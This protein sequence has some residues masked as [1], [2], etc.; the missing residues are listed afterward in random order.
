MCVYVCVCVCVC[1]ARAPLLAAFGR[2]EGWPTVCFA[3]DAVG[4]PSDGFG[5]DCHG[6]RMRPEFVS[7]ETQQWLAD[8]VLF[9]IITG[10]SY[11]N[12]IQTSLCNWMP[13]VPMANLL[14]FTDVPN[15]K[16]HPTPYG[17]LRPIPYDLTAFYDFKILDAGAAPPLS[18]VGCGTV[19]PRTTTVVRPQPCWRGAAGWQRSPPSHN[20]DVHCGTVPTDGAQGSQLKIAPTNPPRVAADPHRFLPIG[21]S[22]AFSAVKKWCQKERSSMQPVANIVLPHHLRVYVLVRPVY[23]LRLHAVQPGHPDVRNSNLDQLGR[24]LFWRTP[25]GMQYC[26]RGCCRSGPPGLQFLPFLTRAFGLPSPASSSSPCRLPH[27]QRPGVSGRAPSAPWTQLK[28][29]GLCGPE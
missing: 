17:T 22:S 19:Q 14:L 5:W 13:H 12:R 8:N 11:S 26:R 29:G 7:P 1:V 16:P 18:G 23:S 9:A 21:A 24:C 3:Q 2:S 27:H 10:E 20:E 15:P 4:P 25:S 28:C 6:A